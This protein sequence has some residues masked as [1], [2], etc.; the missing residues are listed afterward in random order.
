IKRDYP[1]NFYTPNFFIRI[2]LFLFSIVLSI[3]AYSFLLLISGGFE[4]GNIGWGIRTLIFS[5]GVGAVLYLI[6]SEKKAYCAGMDDALAYILTGSCISTF[7]LFFYPIWEHTRFETH[8]GLFFSLPILAFASIYFTDR[9]LT[10]TTLGALLHFYFL[11]LLEIPF[12][13]P[14]LPFLCL[15]LGCLLYYYSKT[16]KVNFNLRY[17]AKCLE[18]IEM[19]S[20]FIIYAS[21]NYFVV[22]ELSIELMSLQLNEGEDI[23][24]A[25]VFYIATA[26]IPLI[27]IVYGLKKKDRTMFRS[28]LIITALSVLTFKYYFSLGHHE[29]TLTVAGTLLTLITFCL[30]RYLK[31]AKYDIGLDA[32]DDDGI[33]SEAEAFLLS[34]TLKTG[35][36]TNAVP[37]KGMDF[38]GGKFG[39]GGNSGS[40]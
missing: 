10:L 37:E 4:G 29:I 5:G 34:Q 12:L 17:W 9:I 18:V 40:F 15:A 38:N 32:E 13:K 27:Y 28:G 26:T 1:V 30:F 22:R 11:C 8:I 24:L 14:L 23:P 16:F 3:A 20:L 19:A 6:I 7:L 36:F 31:T 39:G 21:L 25:I 33:K 2:T 35:N